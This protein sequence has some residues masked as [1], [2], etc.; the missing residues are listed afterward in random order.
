MKQALRK[1]L[2]PLSGSFAVRE[3]V[4]P[5]FDPNWHFHPHYQLF[6]V[7][8]GTGTRFIGDS[9]RPF[10]EGD[11]VMLGPNLPH[12]WRSDKPYFDT[13]SPLRTRGIVVYFTENFLGDSFFQHQEMGLLRDLLDDARRGLEWTGPTQ[14]RTILSL[15]QLCQTPPGFGRV[16]AFMTILHDLSVANAHRYITTIGYTN[17]AKQSETDRIQLVHDYVLGHFHDHINLDTVADLAGMTPS[18][19]CRY[20][21]TRANKTFSDFVAEV[22]V[23]HACKLLMDTELSVTQISFESGYRTLSNFNRQFKEVT[24]QTPSGYLRTYRMV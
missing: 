19:F 8:E 20:F 13:H 10:I 16:L 21:K 3:L 17:T 15:R 24:G 5:H 1:D 14:Q 9:I 6:L 22:R 12:L 11:L 7:E 2:E 4:E 23:G 18:A